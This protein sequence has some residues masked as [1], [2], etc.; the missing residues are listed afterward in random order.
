MTLT[1][2]GVVPFPT[3]TKTMVCIKSL[4]IGMR[5]TYR[6]VGQKIVVV[7]PEITREVDRRDTTVALVS[8]TF[9]LARMY[10][11]DI[12]DCRHVRQ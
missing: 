5:Y 7:T 6:Q 9:R 4:L 10:A 1:H 8:L 3:V 12:A 2:V 11:I